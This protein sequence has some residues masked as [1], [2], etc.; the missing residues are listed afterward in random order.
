MVFHT[1]A[2]RVF[3]AI[4]A[5]KMDFTNTCSLI[6]AGM[7]VVSQSSERMLKLGSVGPLIMAVRIQP[8]KNGHA[9]WHANGVVY[10]T[11]VKFHAFGGDGVNIGCTNKAVSVA[12]QI[13]LPK[14]IAHDN[15][16]IF[17]FHLCAPK[18]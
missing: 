3:A 4:R 1:Y 18:S 5:F 15:K 16:Q 9:V 2:R 17:L 12:A 11:L 14:L 6:T 13:I 7:Q 8:G 10:K